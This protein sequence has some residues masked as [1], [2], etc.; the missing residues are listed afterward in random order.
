MSTNEVFAAQPVKP[1]A[2]QWRLARAVSGDRRPGRG[3]ALASARCRLT[4]YGEAASPDGEPGTSGDRILQD[5]DTIDFHA[6]GVARLEPDLRLH[7]EPDPGRRAGGDHVA[8]LK[9]ELLRH[10]RDDRRHVEDQVVGVAV[11]AE[12]PVDPGPDAQVAWIGQLVGQRDGWP[13]RCR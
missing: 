2:P 6:D 7:P 12:V 10:V 13:E 3:Q 9:G 1:Q 5:A 11:L 8:R 4:R